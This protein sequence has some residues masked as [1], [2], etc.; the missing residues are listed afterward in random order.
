[1][2]SSGPGLERAIKITASTMREWQKN[3]KAMRQNLPEKLVASMNPLRLLI[4]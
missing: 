1:M 3:T 2:G 4:P